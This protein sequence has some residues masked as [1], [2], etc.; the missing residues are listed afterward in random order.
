MIQA[1]FECVA[2]YNFIYVRMYVISIW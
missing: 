2:R 1:L